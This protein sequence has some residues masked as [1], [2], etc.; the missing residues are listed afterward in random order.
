MKAYIHFS[1]HQKLLNMNKW[2]KIVFTL[3]TFST[4][5]G[6]VHGTAS[7]SNKIFS[8]E[9]SKLP[10]V[11]EIVKDAVLKDQGINTVSVAIFDHNIDAAVIDEIMKCI[12]KRLSIMVTDF[13]KKELPTANNEKSSIV[14]MVADT[15][16]MVYNSVMLKKYLKMYLFLIPNLLS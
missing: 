15:F 12:P 9:V 10:F 1:V 11:C 2:L 16:D 3:L 14:I 6:Q 8:Q 13:R 5:F 7:I 4:Y